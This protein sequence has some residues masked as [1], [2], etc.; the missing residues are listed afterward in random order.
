M[1]LSPVIVTPPAAEPVTLDQAKQ[2]LRVD[3]ADTDF[4]IEIGLQIAGARGHVEGVTSTLLIKQTVEIHA[5]DFDDL[6]LFKVGP[7]SSVDEV[8]YLDRNGIVQTVP[9][10]SYELV[11]AAL[12][13]GLSPVSGGSWPRSASAGAVTVRATVGYGDDG[14]AIPQAVRLAILLKLRAL[15]E[16]GSA[17]IDYLLVNDRIWL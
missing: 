13:R 11:G 7:I 9:A 8:S 6:A 2:F 17:D 1:W 16:D 12:E 15:F 14:D 10:E 4:D 3:E 5:D